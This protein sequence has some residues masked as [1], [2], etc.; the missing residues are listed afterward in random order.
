ML[1]KNDI[2][3]IIRSK[4]KELSKEYQNKAEKECFEKLI[5]SMEW[6]QSDTIMTYIS[7]NREMGTH[8]L[9]NEAFRT[10][11]TVSAPRV[12]GNEMN[13]YVF[14]GMDELVKSDK[15]ILEPLP[16][17]GIIP[18]NALMIMP[19]VAFDLS[20]NRIGYGG[21]FYDKYVEKHPHH[22]R[23]ALAYDFQILESI[24]T[25]THD[26]RPHKII[27]ETRII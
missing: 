2:R 8:L 11:K 18:E 17:E 5:H 10:G 21:G 1:I 16:K 20:R 14:H 26:I 19:G 4:K 23:I 22:I 3:R 25:E 9:I 27:T 7:Y 15:G 13:F 6:Q 12:E 24:M